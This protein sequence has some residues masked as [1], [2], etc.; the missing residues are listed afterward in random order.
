MANSDCFNDCG[1]AATRQKIKSTNSQDAEEP[2][3]EIG[4]MMPLADSHPCLFWRGVE[5]EFLAC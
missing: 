5:F 3:Y 1:L 4:K 2:S